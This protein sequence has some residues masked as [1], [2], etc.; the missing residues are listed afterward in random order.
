MN[1]CRDG[2]ART[3]AVSMGEVER[4]GREGEYGGKMERREW[5]GGEKGLWH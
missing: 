5:E 3:V 4:E 1:V 2:L